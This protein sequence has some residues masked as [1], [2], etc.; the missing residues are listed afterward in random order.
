MTVHILRTCQRYEYTRQKINGHF[1]LSNR[2][3]ER[4]LDLYFLAAVLQNC[5]RNALPSRQLKHSRRMRR[6]NDVVKFYKL[7]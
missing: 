2:E 1:H 5:A 4:V 7:Q 6:C 3:R